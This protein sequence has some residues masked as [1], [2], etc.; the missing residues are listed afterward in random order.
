MISNTDKLILSE[1]RNNSRK[2]LSEISRKTG[3]PVSTI[4]DRIKKLDNVVYKHT[5]LID[6]SRINHNIVVHF[7][8]KTA[9]AERNKV[10]DFFNSHT[11]VNNLYKITNGF[12][13]M[14][15]CIFKD[16]KQL[17]DFNEELRKFDI[18]NKNQFHVIEELKKEEFLT[19][20]QD[21]N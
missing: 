2:P 14:V 9:E 11:N 3:I 4:F 20:K 18:K 10:K 13:F 8:I 6:Y 16:M 17:E 5:S 19:K 1:L 7:I 12:D 21:F 15:E